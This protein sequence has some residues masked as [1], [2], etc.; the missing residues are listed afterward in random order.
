MIGTRSTDTKIRTPYRETRHRQPIRDMCI[1][2]TNVFGSVPT[3]FY[4][5]KPDGSPAS[6]KV[7]NADWLRPRG[8]AHDVLL[9][10]LGAVIPGS[11]TGAISILPDRDT[12]QFRTNVFGSVPTTFYDEAQSGSLASLMVGDPDW[13]HPRNLVHDVLLEPL[14]AVI[15]GSETGVLSLLPFS[16]EW[17]N[18]LFLLPPSGWSETK[19]G[20]VSGGWVGVGVTF[21]GLE[22]A[23]IGIVPEGG[24]YNPFAAGMANQTTNPNQV[25]A[26]L[27]ATNQDAA[28]RIKRLAN[29]EPD[30]DGCG[31]RPPTEEAIKATVELLLEAHGLIQGALEMPFI[32]PLPE[33]GLDI[34]WD[35]DSGVELMFVIPPTGSDIRFLLDEPTSSGD[36]NESDG[37]IPK[38]TTLGDLINRL[39]Q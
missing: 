5:E 32:S 38:D 19:V 24:A 17:S 35:L 21:F 15:P 30:W 7:G 28:A 2:R 3:T 6:L 37:V 16:E 29:L 1:F 9:E 23:S 18:T 10:P 26:A 11:E 25:L 8:L 20:V 39:I 4:D 13:F 12:S 22:E 33:G 36:I 27:Q 34:E 31:G 14:D